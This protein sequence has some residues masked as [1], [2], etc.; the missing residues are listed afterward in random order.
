[1]YGAYVILPI[2]EWLELRGEIQT[3]KN[4]DALLS[5]GGINTTTGNGI[6]STSGWIQATLT[7]IDDFTFNVLY[8]LDDRRNINLA[9]GAAKKNQV[10]S[11]NVK[12]QI[13]DPLVIGFEYQ[14][15]KTDYKADRDAT[16]HMG[17]VSMI[18]NF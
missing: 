6:K 9:A 14:N 13:F 11:A 5:G 7:P 8:G 17:W 2:V 4:T 1:M 18:F 15:F 12:V 10:V 16:A 3:G